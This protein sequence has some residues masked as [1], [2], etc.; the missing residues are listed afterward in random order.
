MRAQFRRDE[1]LQAVVVGGKLTRPVMGIG[2]FRHPLTT[3]A[4]LAALLPPNRLIIV[5]SVKHDLT[6]AVLNAAVCDGRGCKTP[7]ALPS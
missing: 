6:A 5:G 1:W 7:W 4:G 3:S 2:F